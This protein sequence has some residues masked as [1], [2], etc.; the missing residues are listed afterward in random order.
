MGL[1]IKLICLYHKFLTVFLDFLKNWFQFRLFNGYAKLYNIFEPSHKSKIKSKTYNL[2]IKT[3]GCKLKI[4][5]LM[6]KNSKL[7]LIAIEK[8]IKQKTNNFKLKT[9]KL[10]LNVKKNI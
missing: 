6:P 10:N 1:N 4:K 7:E 3:K 9:K 8:K 2:T 5:K